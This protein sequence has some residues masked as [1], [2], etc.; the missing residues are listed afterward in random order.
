VKKPRAKRQRAQKPAALAPVDPSPEARKVAL[1]LDV[2][3]PPKP[4]T[5]S[6]IADAI[7][8]NIISGDRLHKACEKEGIK[9]HIFWEWKG[10][11]PDLAQRYARARE[12]SAESWED[13]STEHAETA[14]A[15]NV[16]V[17]RLKENNA[18]W[19]AKMANPAKFADHQPADAMRELERIGLEALLAGAYKQRIGGG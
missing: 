15:E 4:R 5:R 2:P 19:R 9:W 8:V 11:D 18:R 3:E 13:K 12:A 10:N 7:L 1:T 14:T 17:A 16:N 6:E